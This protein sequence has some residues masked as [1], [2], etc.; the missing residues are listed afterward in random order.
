MACGPRE[1][2]F[3]RYAKSVRR[4]L[5]AQTL[6]KGRF[7]EVALFLSQLI[8]LQ[9]TIVRRFLFLRHNVMHP[10]TFP[11]REKPSVGQNGAG[12]AR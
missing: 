12:A 6:A 7:V 3:F 4:S 1:I 2:S 9:K 8:A 10:T 5:A 11:T